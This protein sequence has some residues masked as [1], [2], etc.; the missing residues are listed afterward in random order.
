MTAASQDLSQSAAVQAQQAQN[1]FF[2]RLIFL[3]LLLIGCVVVVIVTA[4]FLTKPL[5][6]LSK[7][8]LQVHAGNFDVAPI[9]ETVPS[10][11]VATTRR[12]TT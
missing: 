7:N 4:R 8:A 10:E 11:V 2:D 1:A 12:S 9:A 3:A 6:L 5:T